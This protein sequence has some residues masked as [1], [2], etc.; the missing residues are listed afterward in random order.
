MYLRYLPLFVLVFF[1]SL[2]SSAIFAQGMAASG[3]APFHPVIIEKQVKTDQLDITFP[4]LQKM[5]DRKLE[6][7]INSLISMRAMEIKQKNDIDEKDLRKT[8]FYVSYLPPYLKNNLLSIRFNTMYYV[9]GTAHPTNLV[10]SITINL[11]NGSEEKLGDLFRPNSDY[12]ARL[13]D[14]I[15]KEIKEKDITISGT[16]KGIEENQGFYLTKEGL[17]IYYNEYTPH[18]V[19]PLLFAIP[20]SEIADLLQ[21]SL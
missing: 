21:V 7:Q 2:S 11:A 1:N 4:Q 9:Q 14:R 19:G 6:S 3:E 5:E 17:V 8:S 10:K 20:Y 18:A 16:F 12:R 15:K 13:N